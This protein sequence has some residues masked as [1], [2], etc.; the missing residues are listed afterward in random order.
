M[1]EKLL[2]VRSFGASI[3]HLTHHH[4]TFLAFL[5]KLGLPFMVRTV[6]FAFLGCWAL[7]VPTFVIHF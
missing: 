4:A 2:G 3:D 1:L 5:G 7:I 6:A